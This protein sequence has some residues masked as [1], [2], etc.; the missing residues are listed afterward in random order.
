MSQYRATNRPKRP[1]LTGDGSA[2]LT[3]ERALAGHYAAAPSQPPR[4]TPRPP[5]TASNAHRAKLRRCYQEPERA[6]AHEHSDELRE[7]L[8]GLTDRQRQFLALQAAGLTYA[9][10][11]QRTDTTLH[12]VERQILRGRRKLT[13]GG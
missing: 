5:P 11:A 7:Q 9:E 4:T 6:I 3:L 13:D 8:R 1:R 12:T 10:I 2:E